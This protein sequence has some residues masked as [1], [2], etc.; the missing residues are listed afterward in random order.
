MHPR[1]YM[2]MMINTTVAESMASRFTNGANEDSVSIRNL[3]GHP[4]GTELT[5]DDRRGVA[6]RVSAGQR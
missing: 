5:H 2:K 4:G 6:L 1:K 3:A